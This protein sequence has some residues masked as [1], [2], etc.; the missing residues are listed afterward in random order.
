MIKN[1][2]ALSMMESLEYL[3][4][5]DEKEKELITF[6]KKF[7]K[8]GIKDAKEFRKKLEELNLIKIKSEH[9]SKI[10]DLIPENVQDL[11]KIFVDVSLDEDEIKKILEVV[12]EFK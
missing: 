7:S 11:N 5:A 6:I 1:N 2:K 9:I 12:K 8:L 10:I 3:K 4:K